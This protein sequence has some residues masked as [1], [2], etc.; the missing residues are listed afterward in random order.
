[1]FENAG[2]GMK[3]DRVDVQRLLRQDESVEETVSA[4]SGRLVVTTHRVLAATP[5]R[6]GPNLADAQRPNVEAIEQDTDGGTSHL[7]RG[8]KASVVGLAL[9][10]A[11]LVTDLGGLIGA[12]SVSGD[13]ANKM[14][15]GEVVALLDVLRTGLA[16]LDVALLVGGALTALVGV[17]SLG[18]FLRARQTDLVVRVAGGD[19]LKLDATIS[20][21]DLAA[22]QRRLELD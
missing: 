5:E 8:V 10:G 9:L 20:D 6:D 3:M 18:L 4:G 14:G 13:T 2:V 11:G 19:D 1:M 15:V 22:L 7:V 17:L 16:L 12:A 21:A